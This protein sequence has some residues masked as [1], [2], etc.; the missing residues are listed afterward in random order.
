MECKKCGTDFEGTFCPN[1]GNASSPQ[2]GKKSLFKKWWFWTIIAVIIISIASNSGGGESNSTNNTITNNS[3]IANTTT[4]E[5]NNQENTT[6][7]A[8]ASDNTSAAT[9]DN[10]YNVGDIINANGLKITYV[11]A[12]KWESSNMFLQPEDGYVYIRL[13]VSAENTSSSD[14]YISSFEFECYADGRKE[15][16]SYVGDDTLEGGTLS[17]GRKT[18]GYIYFTVPADAESI[19]V[20][21]ETS[22]WTDKKAILIVNL[23]Q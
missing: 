19:E 20:E 9:P 17:A 23:A 1:C 7:E 22:F 14:R 13:K 5:S 4:E 10:I 16:S 11:S 8:T 21:Y 12:E 6:T 18:D 3:T 2:K 15:S